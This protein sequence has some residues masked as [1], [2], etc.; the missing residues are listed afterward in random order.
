[1]DNTAIRPKTSGE[2]HVT[3][4][5]H[6][7][8]SSP[9]I[10]LLIRAAKLVSAEGEYVC[11]LRDVST[12]GVSLRL[13]HDLP[14]GKHFDL[15]LQTG[16]NYGIEQI[17]TS[18]HEA[19]FRFEAPIELDKVITE[20]GRFPK[21]GVRLALAI[22]ITLATVQQRVNATVLNLSQ[23]GARIACDALL[24]IDQNV[25]IEGGDLGDIRAKVRWRSGTEYG[26]VFEDTFT[27][28]RLARLAARLQNP[29]LLGQ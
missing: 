10:A 16:R 12:D 14:P 4:G 7:M 24:A 5:A 2:A 23:Q 21:R 18:R 8:R 6:E 13:F 1:M 9:R 22:P 19:G 27:L 20:K 29:T 25:R 15:V 3:H 26:L 28:E 11:V 17:W